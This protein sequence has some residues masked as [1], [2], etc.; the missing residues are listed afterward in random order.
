M[1]GWMDLTDF[2]ILH[3]QPFAGTEFPPS[4]TGIYLVQLPGHLAHGAAGAPTGGTQLL[5][6]ILRPA[7]RKTKLEH[8]SSQPSSWV[9]L[10]MKHGM[11][12]VCR[13]GTQR[14]VARARAH[15]T[16]QAIA[17]RAA[18]IRLMQTADEPASKGR[19]GDVDAQGQQTE[20]VVQPL[21]LAQPHFI[22]GLQ[23]AGTQEAQHTCKVATTPTDSPSHTHAATPNALPP[24]TAAP[25]KRGQGIHSQECLS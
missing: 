3:F 14:G 13:A 6:M 25:R 7:Q 21:Q 22:L 18:E 24:N 15:P 20:K 1:D 5:H 10:H 9:S 12:D 19:D 17:Q 2:S 11:L 4:Q 16:R 8:S 23:V